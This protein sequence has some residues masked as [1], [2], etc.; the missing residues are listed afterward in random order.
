MQA[1][2]D[3]IY[4]ALDAVFLLEMNAEF[5]FKDELGGTRLPNIGGNTIWLGP[6]MLISPNPQ[7][8][9]KGEIQFPIYEDLNGDQEHSEFRMMLGIDF[10]FEECLIQ[11][12]YS[13][14]R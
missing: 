13:N 6:T 10:H 5:E 2:L 7:W 1:L 3:R 4:G 14:V 9:F 12:R 11:R 8:M